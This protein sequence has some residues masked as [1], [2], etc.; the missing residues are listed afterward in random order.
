MQP[1][2]VGLGTDLGPISEPAHVRQL[3]LVDMHQQL[4]GPLSNLQRRHMGQEVVATK[5]AHENYKG[6][7]KI[8]MLQKGLEP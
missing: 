6:T 7:T 3:L 8:Q 1:H 2:E 4:D 5:E